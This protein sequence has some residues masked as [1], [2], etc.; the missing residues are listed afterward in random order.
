MDIKNI[1]NIATTLLYKHEIG[2]IPQ[3]Y[4]FAG[5]KKM[6]EGIE[7][8]EKKQKAIIKSQTEIIKHIKKIYD[9]DD[10]DEGRVPRKRSRKCSKK[11]SRKKKNK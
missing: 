10:Y 7:K 9:D 6:Y 4:P 5:Y 1:Y 8:E 2:A 3:I 11:K